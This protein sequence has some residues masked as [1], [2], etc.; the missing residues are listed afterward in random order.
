MTQYGV[1]EWNEAGS[2]PGHQAVKLCWREGN[3]QRH[4]DKLNAKGGTFVVREV[5]L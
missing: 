4:A 1:F 5:R 2:Y 3:A